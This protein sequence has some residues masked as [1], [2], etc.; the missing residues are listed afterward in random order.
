[1]TCMNDTEHPP[2]THTHRYSL[3]SIGLFSPLIWRSRVAVK[4]ESLVSWADGWG[5][6]GGAVGVDA[7][8]PT[9]L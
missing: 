4:P 6:G 5:G 3:T 7:L 1:M 8:S 2:N 9:F